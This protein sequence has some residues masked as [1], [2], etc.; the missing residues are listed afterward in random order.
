TITFDATPPER[1][2][3]RDVPPKLIKGSPLPV[4]ALVYDPDSPIVRGVFFVGLLKDGKLPPDV[5]PV[6]A[7]KLNAEDEIWAAELPL[8][9]D[10]KSVDIRAQFTNAAGQTATQSVKVEL[11]D[12]MGPVGTIKGKVVENDRTQPGLEVALSDGKEIKAT[13]KTDPKG[14]FS[15]ENVKP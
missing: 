7:R 9:K 13:V 14:E 3:F 15:F 6:D 8:P 11:V 12:P 5:K 4:K 1:I 2:V 10:Q